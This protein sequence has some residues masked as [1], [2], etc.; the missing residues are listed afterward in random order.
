MFDG[1]KR[2]FNKFWYGSEVKEVKVTPKVI[3]KNIRKIQQTMDF[4]RKDID[5]T[6]KRMEA[7]DQTTEDGKK[8]YAALLEEFNLKSEAYATLQKE[9]EQEY[10]TLKKMK[11]TRFFM[12]PKDALMVCGTIVLGVFAISLEREDPR[13]IRI[14][15]FIMKLMPLHI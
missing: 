14:W 10:T 15:S 9:Q 3:Q 11:D 13:A 4:I 12:A 8:K 7:V 1:L 2:I 6:V 5:D